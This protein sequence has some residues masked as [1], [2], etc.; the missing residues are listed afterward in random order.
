MNVPPKDN[1]ISVLQ[2]QE[3]AFSLWANDIQMDTSPV[4]LSLST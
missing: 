2:I 1:Q 3:L 4:S